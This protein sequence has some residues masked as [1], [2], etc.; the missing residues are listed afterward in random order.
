M[1]SLFGRGG[2]GSQN[3]GVNSAKVEMAELQMDM[4]TDMFQRLSNSCFNKCVSTRYS[5]N[6]LTAGESLCIDRCVA[7]YIDTTNKVGERMQASGGGPGVGGA[8]PGGFGL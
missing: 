3:A 7:K 2:G 6:N 4:M 8:S 5:E 1:A